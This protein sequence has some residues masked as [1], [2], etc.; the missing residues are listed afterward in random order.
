MVVELD[1]PGQALGGL[2]WAGIIVQINFLVLDGTPQP[3]GKNIVKRASPA[4]HADLH[5]GKF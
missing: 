2:L 3:L 1:V 5:T 4:I